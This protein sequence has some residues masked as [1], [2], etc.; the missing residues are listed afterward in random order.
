MSDAFWTL[1]DLREDRAFL[2][3]VAMSL[4][5]VTIVGF[6]SAYLLSRDKIA[7]TPIVEISFVNA[8]QKFKNMPKPISEL[9]Q[10]TELGGAKSREAKENGY[11][12]SGYVVSW[13]Q[14]CQRKVSEKADNFVFVYKIGTRLMAGTA[15]IGPKTCDIIK[16]LNDDEAIC[17]IS[18]TK[19]NEESKQVFLSMKIPNYIYKY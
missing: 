9:Y 19:F 15:K 11:I 13:E 3:S 17:A 12:W 7:L 10:L 6:S 5:V 18:D 16:N 8:P 2:L 1:H 14:L 4:A